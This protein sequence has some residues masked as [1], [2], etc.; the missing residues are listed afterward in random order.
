MNE[1]ELY[2]NYRILTQAVRALD[3][4]ETRCDI[5]EEDRELVKEYKKNVKE[6]LFPYTKAVFELEKEKDDLTK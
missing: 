2:N 1:T 5:S 6:M 3:S 4:V